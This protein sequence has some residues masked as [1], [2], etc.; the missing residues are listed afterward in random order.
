M[1]SIT[2]WLLIFSEA[3]LLPV[4]RYLLLDCRLTT[5]R[6]PF[7]DY[8]IAVYENLICYQIAVICYPIA[9]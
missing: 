7:D 9:V 1:G 2:H 4:C 3:H 8:Q 6:L 5:T